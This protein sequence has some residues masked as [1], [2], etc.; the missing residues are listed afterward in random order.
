MDTAGR[1][2]WQGQPYVT[3]SIPASLECLFRFIFLAM[4]FLPQQMCSR[5]IGELGSRALGVYLCMHVCAKAASNV[6]EAL[7]LPHPP[8]LLHFYIFLFRSVFL[9]AFRVQFFICSSLV[10]KDSI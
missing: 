5:W 10:V 1:D 3:G 7:Q 4:Q 2:G 6:F 8:L 9:H